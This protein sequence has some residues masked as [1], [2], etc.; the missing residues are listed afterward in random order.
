[1]EEVQYIGEHLGPQ[2][3]GHFAM[4]VAFFAGILS[5]ISYWLATYYR[6]EKLRGNRWG[7][8]GQLSFLAHGAAVFTVIGTIFFAML[9]Q[10][11]EYNYVSSHVSGDL[12]QRYIF[13]AFWEG[14]EG[15]FLLWMFWHVILG[16]VLMVTAKKWERPVMTVICS[17]QVIIVTMI[18]GVHFGL[19]DWAIKLG[20]NPLLLLRQT[21]DAPIF[22]QAD[23]VALL[24]GSGLNPSLQ[25]YW[26][27]IHPPTLFLGFASTVVPFAFAVAGLWTGDHKGWLRPALRWSLF[28]GGILGIGILM[29]SAWA[30]E[31]L[32]FGGYWAWDPV[33]NTSLVP[34]LLIVAGLHTNLISRATGQGI[35]ATYIFY[36]LG[37]IMTI[38]STFLTRSGLLGD[39][40]VHA[41]TEMGL[42][43]QLLFF[44]CFYVSLAIGLMIWRWRSVPTP[45]KEESVGSR[46]FWMFIGSLVLFMSAVLITGATS[47]PVYNAVR[48]FFDPTFDG[49]SLEDPEQTHNNFQI[50]IAIF[51]GILS[52]VA[53]F[54]R[55]REEKFSEHSKSFLLHSLGA[56]AG[57]VFLSWL[58]TLWVQAPGWQ[59]KTMLFSAWF[60]VWSNA[61]YLVT[62]MRKDAKV[63]G[64]SLSHIGFGLM[65]IGIL[66]SGTNKR[67]ISQNQF[68]MEGLTAE[69]ELE[70]TSITLFKDLPMGMENYE[71]NFVGDSIHGF[72]RTYFVDYIEKDTAGQ[73]IQKFRLEPNILYDRKFEKI[74]ITNPST[75]RYWNR[76][77]FT[78][79]MS[80]PEEE[81]SISAKK[82]KEEELVYVVAPLAIGETHN[83]RDTVRFRSRQDT[84]LVR[85]F[86]ASLKSFARVPEHPDY[87]AEPGDIGVGATIV[88]R[89]DAR[90]KEQ[91][92]RQVAL[93]LRQGLLYHYPAQVDDIAT[94]IKIDESVFD[95]LLVS[96]ESLDYQEYTVKP[97]T[98]FK[99]GDKTV[100]FTRFQSNPEVP[101]YKSE[102]GDLA[103]SAIL[104][105]SASDGSTGTMEPV[106]IIRENVPSRVRDEHRELGLFANLVNLN[107]ETSEATL[108]IAESPSRSELKIPIAIASKSVRSDWITLQAIEFPGINLFWFGTIGMMLGMLINMVVRLRS[109]K[110]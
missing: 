64:S 81:Q 110:G 41:F 53:H 89:R 15:S 18:L 47:L 75:K 40:S 100:T 56:V 83:F 9:N 7:R 77:V 85:N 69:E 76:D 86:T 101:H 24:K 97:G 37:F 95:Q 30:Y 29:G 72:N 62:F 54:L 109:R 67:I 48:E 92:E 20:S 1:M 16:Y 42:E 27:T 3:V 59:H 78:V 46:E 104:N 32:N 108:L 99:V 79:I 51:L 70:R 105:I 35:R 80:M 61:D 74:A 58:T 38:Y 65:I 102:A 17:V 49:L 19:G 34:W 106:F 93:V 73:V 43:S 22:Q 2:Y 25:N 90:S 55:W 44:I 36:L 103:V 33:E 87:I 82:K 52:G 107:P 39:T 63:F 10:Y 96:E 31:A 4:L 13:A 50:Y 11:Y 21:I 84:F 94:R 14:Q 23:Y 8:L 5:M 60:A 28:S 98:T 45:E 57:A 68:L 6:D 88:V 12:Q 66:A 26:M 71:L 91:Y